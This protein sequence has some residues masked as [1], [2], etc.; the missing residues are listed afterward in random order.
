MPQDFD[1]LDALSPLDGRYREAVGHRYFEALKK[2]GRLADNLS[3]YALIHRRV[4]V[5]LDYLR[6]FGKANLM[7]LTPEEDTFLLSVGNEFTRDDAAR[8]KEIEKEVN[9][10]VKAVE[11]WLRERLVGTSLKDRLHFIHFGLTSEDVNALSYGVCLRGTI[12]NIVIPALGE[13]RRA[14]DALA[15]QHAGTIMLARTHGQP[16]SP[17]TF[18]K[19]MRVFEARLARAIGMLDPLDIP[20]KFGGATGTMAAH[21]AALPAIDWDAFTTSFM[22]R[23]NA[24]D[25]TI[26]LVRTYATTQIDPHDGYA[27]L[28]DTLRRANTILLDLSQDLW[29]YISDGWIMQKKKEGEVGSSTMPHK[30]NPIDFENAEG[31][32]G[33]ANALFEFYSRKLPISRLQR[34]LSD[35]TVERTF[36]TAFGH[37]LIAYIAIARGLGKLEINT[38]A[39]GDAV[40][41]H[42]EVL[43]EAIQTILRREG[44]ADAYELL[45]NLTRG[46][47]VTL[48]SLRAFIQTLPVSD[49]VKSE[50]SSLTPRT[51]V[52]LAEKIAKED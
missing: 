1:P 11:Y 16:A 12:G 50:L 46:E 14:L 27:E 5:E 52:G 23:Y 39:M 19:E 44:V 41:Q 37:A 47:A 34:D 30:V 20:V 26:R 17:T 38:E 49:A 13:I 35:S 10:D 51:Y 8:V 9:H 40:D 42:P 2:T 24:P 18:G 6:E 48:E 31:N 33:V 45:K 29:R 4:V 25:A 7:S 15:T 43:A 3:E 32:L 22:A 21:V 28:F 36:G